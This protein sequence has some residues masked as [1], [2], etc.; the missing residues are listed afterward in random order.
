MKKHRHLKVRDRAFWAAT[1]GYLAF[2]PALAIASQL[3]WSKPLNP[4][5][6]VMASIGGVVVSLLFL[7]GIPFWGAG[8]A[9]AAGLGSQ[10]ERLKLGHW[11]SQA[12]FNGAAGAGLGWLAVIVLTGGFDRVLWEYVLAGGIA[13]ATGGIV[14]SIL[15]PLPRPATDITA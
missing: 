13:G 7:I 9:I 15:R 12:V 10:L 6:F 14:F 1:V 3:F 11:L 8:F 2:F 5:E 4:I